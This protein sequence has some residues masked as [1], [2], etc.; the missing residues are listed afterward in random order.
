MQ[1]KPD[2]AALKSYGPRSQTPG[3]PASNLHD[4][5]V[6]SRTRLAALHVTFHTPVG[7]NVRGS[8]DSSAPFDVPL[9]YGLAASHVYCPKSRIDLLTYDLQS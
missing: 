6:P 9:S 1:Y 7:W 4:G 3:R 5:S 8:S 2:R